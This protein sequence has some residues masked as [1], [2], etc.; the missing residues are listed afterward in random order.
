MAGRTVF[1]ASA[2]LRA[3][4]LLVPA[5]RRPEWI[6]EWRGEV[7]HAWAES[8]REGRPGGL[9]RLHLA[10]RA[11]DSLSDAL[12]LRR[13][14]RGGDGWWWTFRDAFRSLRRRPGFAL[15]VIGTL[16][17]GMGSATAIY[18]ILDG[19]MFRPI[20]FR[21]AD[22]LVSVTGNGGSPYHDAD[23]LAI[24]K[25]QRDLFEGVSSYT[26][27]NS[28]LTGAGEARR[29]ATTIAEPGFLD[30][31]GVR[32]VLGRDFTLQEAQSG[33]RVAL[34]SHEVWVDAFGRDPMVLGRPVELD[35][36]PHTI[37][38]VLPP[39][40][41]VSP[42]GVVHLIV[43]PSEPSA[44][45]YVLARL[46]PGVTLEAGEA[47]LSDLAAV[48]G[49]ERPREGGWQAGL[50][51]VTRS[52]GPQ[53]IQGFWM[54]GAAVLCLLLIACANAA[55]LF[56]LRGVARKP[57]LALRVAL[58]SSRASLIRHVF[59]ESMMVAVAAGLVGIAVAWFGVRGLLT[60]IPSG[61]VRFSYT[62]VGIDARV[63]TFAFALTLA[64]GLLFGVVPALRA[65]S[66]TAARAGRA[67]TASR[68]DVR[69]RALVQVGQLALAVLL[70]A[71]A[72]LFGRSFHRL[73][74]VP[75]GYD[76]DRT[77]ELALVSLESLR[78]DPERAAAHSFELD[79]RLA[80]IPGVS[81]VGRTGGSGFMFDYTIELEDGTALA[82]GSEMLPHMSVDTAFFRVMG[83]RIAEGRGFQAVDLS[84]GASSVVVDRDL[85]DKLWP[86]QSAVGR[87]FRIR[88]EPWRTVVG[89]SADVKLDGPHDPYGPLMLFYPA[90]ARE[91]RSGTVMIRTD[92]DP[93]AVLPAVRAVVRELDPEQ[94]ISSLATGRQALGETIADPRFLL[95]IM[96]VFAVVAATLAAVGVYGLVSFT[97][98]QRTREIGVRMAL[99]ARA[100]RVV[101]EVV[102]WG[103]VL[104]VIGVGLGIGAAALLSRSVAAL[105]FNV[106]PLDPLALLSASGALLLACAA[107]LVLPARRA[108]S[109]QPVESLR[110]E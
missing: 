15:A 16:A 42:D 75:L 28:I 23:A 29:Y 94:P 63:L 103:L 50:R 77:A 4:S 51:P 18:T 22:R 92:G 46:Q 9:T 107:A 58:G 20:P 64:T 37:V 108:A 19:L 68:R 10:F 38:G 95:G 99:G 76:A 5:W 81:G 83:I 27:R 73:L 30:F 2:V 1:P 87:R 72:G 11:L 102:G 101:R 14:D 45:R 44:R 85:A 82:S 69:A 86:G 21:D 80:A 24:W 35:G 79:A 41:R 61:M 53:R 54:L 39:T 6:A 84:E 67:A 97:V 71:G 96:I 36:V 89:V 78:G 56:F 110:V 60:L 12:W 62:P 26:R 74:S 88:D 91:L 105:L 33:E 31:L 43:P 93:A 70:L 3:V 8:R 109:V 48:L 90:P 59:A 40:M 7:E 47:R 32:P 106:S 17:L 65:A 52:L 13:R 55:G 49:E 66:T 57:E 100:S 104:G 25:A 34:V 98:A